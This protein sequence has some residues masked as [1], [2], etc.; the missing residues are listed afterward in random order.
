MLNLTIEYFKQNLA[1]VFWQKVLF[2]LNPEFGNGVPFPLEF[3]S[4]KFQA[5]L[6]QCFILAVQ[7][8]TSEETGRC[9]G[10][11][12]SGVDCITLH[13]LKYQQSLFTL[14]S[15]FCSWSLLKKIRYCTGWLVNLM[16]KI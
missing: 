10:G 2:I 6:V 16:V 4:L 1:H 15:G 7:H 9:G 12:F 5:G 3:W 8:L 13:C 14:L 11:E